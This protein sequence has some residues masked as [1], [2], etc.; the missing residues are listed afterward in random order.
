VNPGPETIPAVPGAYILILHARRPIRVRAGALGGKYLEPGYYLY[1]GSARGPG[2][3]RARLLRH[4][5]GA[6]RLRWHVDYL[7]EQT[8]PVSAW[9]QPG[10][11]GVP[12]SVE[13]D[14]ARTLGRTVSPAWPKFGASDCHCP[15]HLFYSATAPSMQVFRRRLQ[16]SG[17]HAG[18]LV[19]LVAAK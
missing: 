13:H 2:G 10:R 4:L 12:R 3:L 15:T 16:G 17:L 14:W 5:Q 19:A 6:E 7:R 11:D 18:G 8:A 1:V 9:W